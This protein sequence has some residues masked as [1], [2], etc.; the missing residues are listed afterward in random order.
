MIPLITGRYE[1][2]RRLEECG[3]GDVIRIDLGI[4]DG[5]ID[6]KGDF[7]RFGLLFGRSVA[8]STGIDCGVVGEE[9]GFDA[10]VSGLFVHVVEFF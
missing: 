10:F 5:L 1:F 7:E 2:V 3:I 9:V 6:G 4:T 8:F